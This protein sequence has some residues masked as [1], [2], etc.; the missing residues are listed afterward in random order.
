MTQRRPVRFEAVA[1]RARADQGAGM[2]GIRSPA[3]RGAVSA[4][5][6]EPCYTIEGSLAKFPVTGWASL[7]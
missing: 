4:W 6:G 2:L 7:A 5:G 1:R 3:Q